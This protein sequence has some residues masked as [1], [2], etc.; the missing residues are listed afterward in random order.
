VILLASE[1]TAI[2]IK[3]SEAEQ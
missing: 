2:H 1:G 3:L